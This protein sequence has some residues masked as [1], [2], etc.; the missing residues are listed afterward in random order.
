MSVSLSEEMLKVLALI[1]EYDIDLED[2]PIPEGQR[3]LKQGDVEKYIDMHKKKIREEKID[4]LI[5]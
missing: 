1:D 2:I 3:F 5:E 4:K